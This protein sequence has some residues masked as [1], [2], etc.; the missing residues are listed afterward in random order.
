MTRTPDAMATAMRLVAQPAGAALDGYAQVPSLRADAD[1]ETTFKTLGDHPLLSAGSL[2]GL[3]GLFGYA[4]ALNELKLLG[5][6]ADGLI[7]AA[8]TP[9]FALRLVVP[10]VFLLVMLV[11]VH[12]TW[13]HAIDNTRAARREFS[14]GVAFGIGVILA[15]LLAV[16]WWAPRD[17]VLPSDATPPFLNP[18]F[19]VLLFF[20]L[21]IGL[22]VPPAR[23]WRKCKQLGA[24]ASHQYQL[25]LNGHLTR[26]TSPLGL[27]RFV[28]IV[29]IAL[30][31]TP[32]F[33]V[34]FPQEHWQ[35][36]TDLSWLTL[37]VAHAAEESGGTEN[38]AAGS[39]R[40]LEN[41]VANKALEIQPSISRVGS[42][43]L[44]NV[45][46]PGDSTKTELLMLPPDAIACIRQRGEKEDPLVPSCMKPDESPPADSER[47]YPVSV[48]SF[49]SKTL[50]C[51]LASFDQKR[52]A[53][54]AQY[55]FDAPHE[56]SNEAALTQWG[57]DTAALSLGGLAG[58]D[59]QGNA[60]NGAATARELIQRLEDSSTGW[61][62]VL[63]FASAY[64]EVAHN[65]KLSER[66][67][68]R[69]EN[70]LVASRAG[71]SDATAKPKDQVLH[72]RIRTRPMGETSLADLFGVDKS[73]GDQLAVA[74]FCDPA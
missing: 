39:T 55:D 5:W 70:F 2:G 3:L 15:S 16:M 62:W 56:G 28:T 67:A 32:R 40:V 71:S 47:A 33:S 60:H 65:L 18:M 45:V 61:I 27:F 44:V 24:V 31:V 6:N 69:L 46:Q 10:F 30:L 1:L 8:D 25:R 53:V 29:G 7:G 14:L 51:S 37:G 41:K 58:I 38:A 57:V 21:A 74:F 22:V 11:G 72:D 20:A 66:R 68:E 19:G 4:K 13:R 50:G 54:V 23:A 35:V 34:L 48:A 63:G 9:D 26:A 12:L 64:G 52:R 49:A 59:A 42:M 17:P 43:L 73:F 36:K